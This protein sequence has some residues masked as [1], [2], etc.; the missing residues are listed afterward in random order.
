MANFVNRLLGRAQPPSG[1]VAKERLAVVLLHDRSNLSAE[2]L[3]RLKAELLEVIA[4]YVD[5]DPDKADI[6]LSMNERDTMLKAEVPI[7]QMSRRRRSA[8]ESS[9]H[10]ADA[11]Y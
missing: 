11:G 6:I 3:E 9:E 10:A 7:E 4:R 8:L 1:T 2:Q 5:F